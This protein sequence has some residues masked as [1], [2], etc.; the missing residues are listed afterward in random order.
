LKDNKLSKY[1]YLGLVELSLKLIPKYE[2]DESL[3]TSALTT[4]NKISKIN[5]NNVVASNSSG[6]SGG[7]NSKTTQK[8]AQLANRA[9]KA[10]YQLWQSVANI[11]LIE[12]NNLLAMDTNGFSD[13]YVKF[14]LENE[15]YRSKVCILFTYY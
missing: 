10:P 14:K 15:R 3:Y 12:G 5:A 13:P 8:P 7:V 6:G 9:K 11:V 2:Y 1:E 4:K